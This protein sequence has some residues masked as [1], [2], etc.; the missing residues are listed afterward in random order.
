MGEAK[1]RRS[2]PAVG[3]DVSAAE[4]GENRHSRYA[5][6][7]SCPHHPFRVAAYSELLEIESRL[8]PD[9][10]QRLAEDNP[11]GIRRFLT[12]AGAGDELRANAIAHWLLFFERDAGGRTFGERLADR[13]GTGLR[14]DERVLLRGKSRMRIALIEVHRVLDAERVEV[15]DLLDRSG[16]PLLIVDRRLAAIAPRFFTG[17]AAI[18]PLPHFWRMSGTTITLGELGPLPACEVVE[19]CVTHLGGPENREARQP[20]LAEHFARLGETFAAVSHERRRLMFAGID[21][22]WGAVTYTLLKPGALALR[23][24]RAEPKV[25]PDEL[26]P[27]EAKAGFSRAFV[28]FAGDETGKARSVGG[29]DSQVLLG[30]LLVGKREWRL[31]AMGRKRLNELRERFE[32]RMGEAVAFSRERVDDLTARMAANEPVPNPGLL[33]SRLLENPSKLLLTTS[34]LEEPPPGVSPA[35][36]LAALRQGN[37]RAWPDESLPALDG[38][39]PRAAVHDPALRPRVIELVKRQV[40]Q[41]DEENRRHRRSD[42]VNALIRTLGLAEIDFPPPP[43]RPPLAEDESSASGALDDDIDP[44]A[45]DPIELESRP[46]APRLSGPPLSIEAARARVV[47]AL[48]QVDQAADGLDELD[49]SGSTLVADLAAMTEGMLEAGE[50]EML[51]PLLLEAWF[52]LVPLG[53]RAPELDLD[54]IADD[55]DAM[56]D[57]LA[58]GSDIAADLMMKLAEASRQPGLMTV[59]SAQFLSGMNEMPKKRRLSLDARMACLIVLRAVVDELDR[60]LRAR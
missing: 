60:A 8:D 30:R 4:C 57:R 32:A 2:C 11:A 6:P 13:A 45:D 7:E 20:W 40:R 56:N 36:H 14:N 25:G 1:K 29:P 28:W 54:A 9:L 27:E 33:P 35:E 5:C 52:A 47:A 44:F 38:R 48:E 41:I 16:Q 37:L 46:P 18:Y 3:R 58:A 50:F 53:A 15:V 23:R 34:R 49:A 22:A 42:D 31:E 10:M 12:M 21:G 55:I 39:T 17:L 51:V 24:L 59:L 43:P 19:T 26:S